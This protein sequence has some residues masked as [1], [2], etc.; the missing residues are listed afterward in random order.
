MFRP[1]SAD[2]LRRLRRLAHGH[3]P[4]VA[5]PWTGSLG[6]E[7]LYWIPFLRWLTT[8]GG[9]DPSRVVAVSRGGVAHWYGPVARRYVELF[10][11][12]LPPRVVRRGD[13]VHQE[14]LEVARTAVGGERAEVLHPRSLWRVLGRG[15]ERRTLP[16]ASPTVHAP[17]R[18]DARPAELP[19]QYAVV[20]LY[21]NDSLPDTSANRE[22]LQRTLERLSE[23]TDVVVLPETVGGHEDFVPADGVGVHPVT[24]TPND[25][26][27]IEETRPLSKTK[28]WKVVE[29]IEKAKEA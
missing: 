27:L 20:K 9:V 29:L 19:E 21:F 26:V 7:L 28:A 3:A 25:L 16:A 1:Q 4:I 5:G 10:D 2:E 22:L 6:L 14:A 23:Q 8:E 13:R 24:L 12:F 11:H 18:A 15:W 17:L